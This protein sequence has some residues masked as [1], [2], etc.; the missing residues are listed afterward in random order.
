M[1]RVLI[2]D[3][4]SAAGLKIL[5]ETPGIEPVVMDGLTPEQVREALAD[6][7]GIIV[8]SKTK[9]TPKILEGQKRL[10]VIVRAGVGVDNIDLPAAT[11]E[12]IIVMNTPAGNTTS[13]AEH[14]L[15]LMLALSRNV[16]PAAAAMKAGK[17]DRNKFTGTQLAGKTLGVVGLGRIGLAVAR[18]AV[19]LEMTVVGYDPFFSAEKAAEQGIELVRDV[20]E[21]VPRVDYL[22]VHTPLTPETENLIDAA[23]LAKM[24]KGVRL[25]NCARGG[26]INETALADAIESGHVGGAALDVFVTEPPA[27]DD[28]LRRLDSVL[29][30]PHLGAST[31]E[32]QESVGVEAAELIVAYLTRNEIRAAVNTA[33]I[34]GTEMS[35]MRLYLDLGYRL[36]RLLAQL[37]KS[38]PV[39]RA[40]LQY[41]GEVANRKTKLITGAF[42]AGLLADAVEQVNLINAEVIAR[43]RGVELI[44]TTSS[45][46]G[47]FA[48]MVSATV[49]AGDGS[50]L[51]AAGTL[52][53]HEYVRLIRLDGFHLDSYLDGQLLVYRHRDV[54]GLI[55]YIGTTLGK[56]HVNI[57]DMALG[58]AKSEPGGDSVAIL[59]VDSEPSAE[60]LAE[61]AAHPE[62]TG[63]QLVKLPPRG[64][65]LPG[66]MARPE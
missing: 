50:T 1:P 8:R 27:A 5:Q 44:E 47:D 6:A 18:R 45:E 66:V 64:T 24:K 9:L 40:Q 57:S 58:R 13:T 17:W 65:A 26:I 2:T 11:R 61:I 48:T 34:S 14:A 51:S 25:I 36:G 31:D 3:G 30:T 63:V 56:H 4:L 43:D 42:A 33:P 12:G 49:E 32:A 54:P 16:A 60:A 10:K 41:R 20:D 28:R 37:N 39:R 21:L 15:A 29:L 53:G 46:S 19:A 62:V 59:N 35:E 52:F 55:G 22:T 23:R 7:D 38:H